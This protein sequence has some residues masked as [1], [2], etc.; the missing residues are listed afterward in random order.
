MFSKSEC[1]IIMYVMGLVAFVSINTYLTIY[2]SVPAVETMFYPF[3][4]YEK[5]CVT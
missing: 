1:M 2:M 4:Q 3:E 5:L